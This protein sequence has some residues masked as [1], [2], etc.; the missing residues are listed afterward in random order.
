MAHPKRRQSNTRTLKRRAHDKAVAPTVAIYPNW[1]AYRVYHTVCATCR[2]Y[3]GKIGSV[4][5]AAEE[6]EE[7][8]L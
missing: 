1:G 6:W 2:D 8:T 4:K 7:E 5:D 3:R